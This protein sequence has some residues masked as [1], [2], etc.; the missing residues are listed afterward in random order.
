MP[1]EKLCKK[2]LKQQKEH[3]I[4]AEFELAL[5]L[6]EIIL[7]IIISFGTILFFIKIKHHKFRYS[8]FFKFVKPFTEPFCDEVS[9][10]NTD[11]L[12]KQ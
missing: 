2:C 4:F 10:T 11:I 5:E 9:S 1:S 7:L 6:L 8:I 12:S 3:D